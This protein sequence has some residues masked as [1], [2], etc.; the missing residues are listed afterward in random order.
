MKLDKT[1]ERIKTQG[2]NTFLD[3]ASIGIILVDTN[4]EIILVNRFACDLFQYQESEL[5]GQKI[6][7][8]IPFRFHQRH[9]VH[10]HKFMESPKSRPMGLGLDL[11]AKKKGGQEF[12]VE[13]SLGTYKID[14]N[15]YIISFIND[16]TLRKQNENS[17]RELNTELEQKV[18]DRT[19]ALEEVVTKLKLQAQETAEAEAELEKS[20]AKEKELG[21]LKSRFVTMAS[22]EF[23][24]PLSTIN[25]SAYLLQK[26]TSSE[27]QIKRDKHLERIISAVDAMTGIL[28][29]FLSVGKIEE[30]KVKAKIN[31]GDIKELI[32]SIINQ[33]N[34][35]LKKGQNIEYVHQGKSMVDFD[36]AL[37]RHIVVNLISNAIKFSPENK[38]IHINSNALHSPWTL[39]IKDEGIGISQQDQQNLYERFYRGSNVLN[40]QGTGLGLHIVAR[41]T[42]LMDGQ[43]SC[44]SELNRGTEFLLK[45]P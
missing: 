43:I 22:H 2:L 44:K 23:R 35:I 26:Y 33:I 24:T 12:P 27:D 13:V 17:I 39:K 42:Q 15:Q 21:E 10:H 1:I 8:L 19:E 5:V 25:S 7:T 32:E 41:Y 36:P 18:K 28:D 9:D 40:I 37:M 14:D 20:L 3:Y 29:D 31:P 30:G 34:P 11:F 45:F 16:I 38:P 4:L 6:E